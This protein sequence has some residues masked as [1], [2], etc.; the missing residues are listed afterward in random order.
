LT[1]IWNVF[2]FRRRSAAALL[3]SG[4]FCFTMATAGV[5]QVDSVTAED[6]ARICGGYPAPA[7]PA[8]ETVPAQEGI[9]DVSTPFGDVSLPTAP[10]AA[11]GMY[12]TDVDILIWLG[13]PLAE[14]QPIRGDNGYEDFPCYFPQEP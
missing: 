6:Q 12:T 9:S 13:F 1:K 4:V 8:L 11:L 5:A 10:R 2:M 3:G 14:R 7:L